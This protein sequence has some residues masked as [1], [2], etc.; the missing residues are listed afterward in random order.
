MKTYKVALLPGDGIGPEIMKQAVKVLNVI[1]EN[2]PVKF[3][4]LS[5]PF[6]ACAFFEL[7][8]AFPEKTMEICDEVDAILKGTIGLSHEESKKIPID[9]QPEREALLPL[10]K[11][12][13]T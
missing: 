7:G 9:E 2:N 5:A 3:E 4:L 12:Y 8:K 13:Q 10:R 11:R 6:G 1:E